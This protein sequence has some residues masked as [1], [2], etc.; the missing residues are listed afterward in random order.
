METKRTVGLGNTLESAAAGKITYFF[1]TAAT[2]QKHTGRNPY[3][4]K[5][6]HVKA[7]RQVPLRES[8]AISAL[9]RCDK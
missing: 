6:Q 2:V 3:I 1:C 5:P 8:A 4:G 7:L 9:V